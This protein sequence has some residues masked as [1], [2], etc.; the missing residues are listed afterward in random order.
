MKP[1]A[2]GTTRR[3]KKDQIVK[4]L[5]VILHIGNELQHSAINVKVLVTWLPNGFESSFSV[6]FFVSLQCLPL[7]NLLLSLLFLPPC[8]SPPRHGSHTTAVPASSRSPGHKQMSRFASC[9]PLTPAASTLSF[10]L[11]E[12]TT[13]PLPSPIVG[14]THA[15]A[16]Y[17]H[18]RHHSHIYRLISA[19][20]LQGGRKQGTSHLYPSA[21]HSRSSPAT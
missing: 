13:I 7:Q 11:R 8:L 16:A 6:Y 1:P 9:Q 21:F 12:H 4:V 3:K 20:A 17:H 5:K 2:R 19:T 18:P 14:R 15:A 10:R